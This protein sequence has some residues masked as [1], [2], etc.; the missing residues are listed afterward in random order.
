MRKL[1]GLG[2]TAIDLQ[3][4]EGQG[5]GFFN[6]DPWQTVTLIAADRFLARQGLLPGEPSLAAPATGEHL[7]PA[8]AGRGF[9][10]P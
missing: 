1:Q 3:L 10:S 5:H 7:V 6:K 8:P 2:N 4:A 9:T